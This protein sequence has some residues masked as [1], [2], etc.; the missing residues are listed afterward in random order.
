[1]LCVAVSGSPCRQQILV[2]FAAKFAAEKFA[3]EKHQC[4]LEL[5]FSRLQSGAI[6]SGNIEK[7]LQHQPQ[8]HH[9]GQPSKQ[10]P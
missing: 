8:A 1:M 10:T 3:A 9:Y 2:K 7:R 4:P 5:T 6:L